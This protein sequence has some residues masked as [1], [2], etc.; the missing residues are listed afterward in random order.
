M[1]LYRTIFD[2]LEYIRLYRTI[3]DFPGITTKIQDY[4]ELY[5]TIQ[6]YKALDMTV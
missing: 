4:I 3:K 1:G 2:Y 5:R 6:D